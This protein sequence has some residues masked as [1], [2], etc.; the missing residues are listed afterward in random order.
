MESDAQNYKFLIHISTRR[1]Y[2]KGRIREKE[3]GER[4][5]G[6]RDKLRDLLKMISSSFMSTSPLIFVHILLFLF[7]I[8]VLF[9]KMSV[10][11]LIVLRK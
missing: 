11:Y 1:D 4:K 8:I 3:K 7:L 10:I 5:I 6:N 2:E 9:E